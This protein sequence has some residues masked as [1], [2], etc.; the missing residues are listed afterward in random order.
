[1]NASPGEAVEQRLLSAG[2]AVLLA[3]AFVAHVAKNSGIR[4]V[5]IKGPGSQLQ[6][7]RPPKQSADVDV[8]VDPGR[9]AELKDAL[10]FL[11]WRPRPVEPDSKAFPRHSETLY[12]PDWPIDVDVHY[13]FPG[14]DVAGG[15]LFESVWN[16]SVSA[17]LAG[18]EVRIPGR[19]MAICLIALHALRSPSADSSQRDLLFLRGLDLA[20]LRDDVVAA[21]KETRATAVLAPFLR[22]LFGEEC[23]SKPNQLPSEEW[24]QL[25]SASVPGVARLQSMATGRRR[26]LP[27]KLFRALIPDKNTL[28]AKD[29]YADTTPRGRVLSFFERIRL[30]V[31]TAPNLVG[32]LIKSRRR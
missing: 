11:G 31:A 4:A 9:V 7:L 18:C 22:Q 25:V 6:G 17:E 24:N 5:L 23:I 8:L 16:T 13:R 20:D 10:G 21:A 3:H 28:L 15:T 14:M 2:E 12:H 32:A 27:R 30:A 19:P 29:L 1:M 26:D